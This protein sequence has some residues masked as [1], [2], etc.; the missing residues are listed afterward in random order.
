[1]SIYRCQPRSFGPIVWEGPDGQPTPAEFLGTDHSLVTE[2]R[3]TVLVMEDDAPLRALI[4]ELLSDDG[5]GVIQAAD[6]R[7]GLRL[8][9][10][11]HPSVILLD[12]GL[13]PT[14]GLQ[15]LRDLRTAEQT[16]YIP[17]V[18]VSGHE[19]SVGALAEQRPDGFIRKPFDLD[20][21]LA[22]VERIAS[23]DAVAS[24]EL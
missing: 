19:P 17:V 5:Y 16:R 7:Q 2:R 23:P 4:V 3:Q 14:S 13:P 21:L 20:N 1:V 15:V 22:H 9:R 24:S 11:H 6:G 10:E 18:A 12:L 8:A